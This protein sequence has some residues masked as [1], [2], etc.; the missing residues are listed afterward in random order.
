MKHIAFIS[1]GDGSQLREKVDEWIEEN[2]EKN[3]EIIDVEYSENADVYY[4]TVT[5]LDK[6]RMTLSF[7]FEIIIWLKILNSVNAKV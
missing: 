7:L 4:A 5:Y 3:I 2:K 6:E 1:E